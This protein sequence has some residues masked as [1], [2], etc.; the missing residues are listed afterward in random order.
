MSRRRHGRTLPRRADCSGTIGGRD[1]KARVR[2]R[3]ADRDGVRLLRHLRI[4]L[5]HHLARLTP[6]D[7]PGDR[8]DRN[9]GTADALSR[10]RAFRLSGACRSPGIARMARYLVVR[11]GCGFASNHGRNV[12][13][14]YTP[15]V[16][17]LSAAGSTQ[18]RFGRPV[19]VADP[20]PAHLA[21]ACFVKQ[22]GNGPVCGLPT[23]RRRCALKPVARQ[24]RQ[25]KWR[26]A[27]LKDGWREKRRRTAWPAEPFLK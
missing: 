5:A 17:A 26:H 3:P 19:N 8:A 9:A 18:L 6:L 27:L 2:T 20:H 14:T 11:V 16:R 23:L 13:V 22:L 15:G 24:Q 12:P 25:R 10:L 21:G 7:Q 1:D 4:V